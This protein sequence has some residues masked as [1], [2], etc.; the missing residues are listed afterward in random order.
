MH[1]ACRPNLDSTRA[2]PFANSCH[3][4]RL[5]T[6]PPLESGY[7]AGSPSMTTLAAA[8]A[9]KHAIENPFLHLV[10][11]EHQI[12]VT[13]AIL[14]VLAMVFLKGFNEAIG[15]AAAAAVPYL[16][17]NLIVLARGAWEIMT[18]PALLA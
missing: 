10:L 12:L 6:D 11:G 2:S 4:H 9:G 5:S 16:A 17:L 1:R 18:H 15:L 7:C 8:D 14:A 3:S 13:L